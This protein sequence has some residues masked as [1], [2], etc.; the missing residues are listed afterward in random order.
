[1]QTGKD[2]RGRGAQKGSTELT[3]C[4]AT[5]GAVHRCPLSVIHGL[6]ISVHVVNGSKWY[7]TSI[8]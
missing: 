2:D 3:V 8:D 7:L 6:P 4:L 5:S 1:M